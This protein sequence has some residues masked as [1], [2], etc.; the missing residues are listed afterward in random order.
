MSVPMSATILP[1]L[2]IASTGLATSLLILLCW[3]SMRDLPDEDRSWHDP[4]PPAFRILWWPLQWLAH[5]LRRWLPARLVEAR[6]Q[7]L[8]LAGLDFALDAVQFTAGQLLWAGLAATF[9]A[10]LANSLFLATG[11]PALVG[12]SLGLILPQWWLRDRIRQR[13]RQT[14][15]TLPFML[16]LITL[17]VESGLSLNS[18]FAQA[19]ARGPAGPLRD[20]FSRLLRDIRAGRGRS[21]ALRELAKRLD[22]PAVSNFVSSLIQAETS[23][24]SL[25]PI[26]RAQ[27]EQGRQERFAQAEKL[28]MQAPVKLLLPLL[29]FIF[30]CVFII[31]LFPIVMKFMAAGS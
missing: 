28:A 7:Q 11:F 25:G 18:A 9:A 24:M 21:E 4:P 13:R 3:R 26:L 23:G 29:A 30:P 5:Y 20:E 8:R 6:Q 1:A 31:L 2:I 14:F 12:A 10:W 17:C 22:L 27:A 15:K 16:D 19:I